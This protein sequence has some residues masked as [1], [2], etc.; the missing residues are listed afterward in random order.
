[1]LERDR[2]PPGVPCWIDTE[3]RDPQRAADFYGGLFGWEFHNRMPADSD[4][5]LVATLRGRPVAAVA[6]LANDASSPTWTT[7]IW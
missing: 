6:R 3:Q 5:Y 2:Y 4:P 7:Y 1:M